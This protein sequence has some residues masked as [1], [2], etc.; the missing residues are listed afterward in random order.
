MLGIKP[1]VYCMVG[2]NSTNEAMFST[3]QSLEEEN[4]KSLLLFLFIIHSLIVE[5]QFCFV[6]QDLN[7][8]PKLTLNL[9]VT[10]RVLGLQAWV[11]SPGFT[12]DF[13]ESSGVITRIY[14]GVLTC[15]CLW[16]PEVD[17]RH[18]PPSLYSLVFER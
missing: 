16:R 17:V 5:T 15:S 7:V 18:L 4:F 10:L 13:W 8:Y 3:S 14:N 2:K 12:Y 9:C 1:M 11:I 6:A